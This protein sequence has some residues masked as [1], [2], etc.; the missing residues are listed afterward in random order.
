MQT[1]KNVTIIEEK[2]STFIDSYVLE[3]RLNGDGFNEFSNEAILYALLEYSK[4]PRPYSKKDRIIYIHG[5]CL[6]Y[7][8]I[9]HYYVDVEFDEQYDSFIILRKQI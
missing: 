6:E 5:K 9:P 4:F 3:F 1:L 7:H 2:L 8:G